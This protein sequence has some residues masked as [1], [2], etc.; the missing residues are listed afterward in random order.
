[1]QK[2]NLVFI[3]GIILLNLWS[4]KDVYAHDV[5]NID[6]LR[7]CIS[8]QE[9]CTLKSNILMFNVESFEEVQQINK[10]AQKL[11]TKART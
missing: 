7:E 8:N 10:I 11:I 4:L 1:M 2:K 9:N 3:I 6:S 5:N